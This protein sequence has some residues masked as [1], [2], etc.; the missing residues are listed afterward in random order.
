[1]R[2]LSP[3]ELLG[4]RVLADDAE[5]NIGPDDDDPVEL[6]WIACVERG[7]AVTWVEPFENSEDPD[8]SER[9]CYEITDLGRLALRVSVAAQ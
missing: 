5:Y 6:G 1:M 8:V 9:D 2:A 7:L 3:V 4:L